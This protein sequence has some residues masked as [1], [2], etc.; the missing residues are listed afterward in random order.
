MHDILMLKT[1]F[2]RNRLLENALVGYITYQGIIVGSES[3]RAIS[4]RKH[5]GSK[6]DD[7]VRNSLLDFVRNGTESSSYTTSIVVYSL[8]IGRTRCLDHHSP[9]LVACP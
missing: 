2:G 6:C 8:Q 5:E 9:D 3:S 7:A 1:V 4:N